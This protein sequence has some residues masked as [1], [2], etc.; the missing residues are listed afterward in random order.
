MGQ[1]DSIKHS[2]AATGVRNCVISSPQRCHRFIVSEN[3][4]EL[5]STSDFIKN[6]NPNRGGRRAAFAADFID[7]EAYRKMKFCCS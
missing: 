4:R 5:S 2:Q 1:E 3:T 7:D 6:S